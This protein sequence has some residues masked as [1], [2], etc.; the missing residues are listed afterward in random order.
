MSHPLV[1]SQ[2]LSSLLFSHQVMLEKQ[3]RLKTTKHSINNEAASEDGEEDIGRGK[4]LPPAQLAQR[5]VLPC[6]TTFQLRKRTV[7]FLT[8]EVC[9]FCPC[10]FHFGGFCFLHLRGFDMSWAARMLRSY[11]C[12]APLKALNMEQSHLPFS[13]LP[14]I[15]HNSRTS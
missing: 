11:L 6:L 13:S 1:T 5:S 3:S 9:L 14:H 4:G 8:P 7:R 15:V 10:D 2:E 12:S